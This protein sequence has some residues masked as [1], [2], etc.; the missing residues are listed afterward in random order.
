MFDIEIRRTFAAAHRLEGYN[1][2][3]RQLHGHNYSVVAT[4][5]TAKL[6]DLGLALDFTIL[7]ARL[8]EILNGYD[9]RCLNELDDFR[10][11]NPTSENLARTI[12]RRLAARIDG[13]EI[14][15][16]SVRIGESENSAVTYFEE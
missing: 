10:G 8:D 6:D 1:G 4:V 2:P 5:R 11:I 9:H 7:K 13:E 12:F 15:L 3:C 16:R 14:R